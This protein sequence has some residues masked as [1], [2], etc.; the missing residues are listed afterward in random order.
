MLPHP[1]SLV[2]L[3]GFLSV[4]IVLH[5]SVCSSVNSHI[6]EQEEHTPRPA[7]GGVINCT[8]DG[9]SA[10]AFTCIQTINRADTPGKMQ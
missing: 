7:A 4:C 1:L 5:R 6:I 2:F 9:A 10:R 3:E 8:R